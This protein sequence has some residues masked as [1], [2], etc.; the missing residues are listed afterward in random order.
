MPFHRNESAS[1]KILSFTV[2]TTFVK[3]NY[4]LSRERITV[5]TQV[6]SDKSSPLTLPE[7][8][9]Q[10]K[11][12]RI[13]FNQ[14]KGTKSHWAPKTSYPLHT[15]LHTI[16]NLPNRHNLFTESY[17]G[18]FVLD[19]YSVHITDELR[20][21]LLAVVVVIGCGITGDVQCN[22]FHVQLLSKKKY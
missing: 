15:M 1:Q 16:T 11:G 10:G 22:Y 5:F 21:A 13:K 20:K 6:F 4:M 2:E 3:E 18:Q 9:F 12:T 19:D 17:Y 7:F 14:P 8:V